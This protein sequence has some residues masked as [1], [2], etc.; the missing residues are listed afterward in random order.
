MC[1]CDWWKTTHVTSKTKLN[2]ACSLH[3][4]NIIHN[5][6][7]CRAPFWGKGLGATY[8]VYLG[9][10]EKRLVDFLLLIIELLYVLRLRRY[11]RKSI[12]DVRTGPVGHKITCTRPTK[13]D[14]TLSSKFAM[15]SGKTV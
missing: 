1:E 12:E 10:I 6:L 15:F 5:Y 3:S 7:T 13:S 8:A 9:L 11:E 14:V 4:C 2:V